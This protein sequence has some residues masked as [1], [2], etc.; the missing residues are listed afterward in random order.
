MSDRHE[1]YA[2]R[3]VGLV[4]V[5]LAVGGLAYL[6]S[7][8]AVAGEA[9]FSG[10]ASA[11]T[12]ANFTVDK[13][14][15]GVVAWHTTVG[16]AGT[17]VWRRRL[18]ALGG[19]AYRINASVRTRAVS[20]AYLSGRFMVRGELQPE[21]S[22]GRH[23]TVGTN[24]RASMTAEFIAPV[25]ATALDVYLVTKGPG[26]AWFSD[27]GVEDDLGRLLAEGD[28]LVDRG[29]DATEPPR[30]ALV[31]R[32]KTISALDARSPAERQKRVR[33][34]E[35]L[36]ST[37]RG[38]E[39]ADELARYAG[40]FADVFGVASPKYLV[41]W[42]GP[43]QRVFLDDL[44]VTME[45]QKVGE[46]EAFRGETEALQLVVSPRTLDL[47]GV[48]ITAGDLVGSGNISSAA[49]EIHPVASVRMSSNSRS[50][51]LPREE[52]YSGWWPDPFLENVPIDVPNGAT[53]AIWVGVHVPPTAAPGRYAGPITIQP[54][55]APPLTVELAVK[56]WDFPLPE[57]WHFQNLLSWHDEWASKFYGSAWTPSLEKKFIDF[58][59]D[60]RVNVASM[61]EGD[62]PY[63]TPERLI[64][65]GR[66]GQNLLMVTALPPEARLKPALRQELEQRLRK[67]VPALRE[68]GLLDRAVA[69]GWDE[70]G[71][72]W[73]FRC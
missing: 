46:L 26:E 31:K 72:Q 38:L 37:V 20:A 53:Q 16:G 23:V 27:V 43:M 42:A 44:P 13:T 66:R 6:L 63:A 33:S 2:P 39:R 52:G 62:E 11:G 1:S 15:S 30:P 59:V 51:G 57:Q 67:T 64:E 56:V 36:R 24:E 68:A 65:L 3:C 17:A 4:S 40:R 18:P 54:L 41:G 5:A 35:Q 21:V 19:L 28:A 55:N 58:L 32:W 22:A 61:Y 73:Y 70:R 9:G 29:R 48:R 34:G 25:G 45:V 8:R 50:E 49:V 14:S 60:H 7:G 69:Y 12:E 71:P 10:W 47:K